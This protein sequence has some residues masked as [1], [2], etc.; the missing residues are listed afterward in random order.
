MDTEIREWFDEIWAYC[1][2]NWVAVLAFAGVALVLLLSV[3]LISAAKREDRKALQEQDV[4]ETGAEEILPDVEPEPET[5]DEAE[6]ETETKPEMQAQEPAE[7]GE[8]Q[9]AAMGMVDSLVKSMERA[10]GASGQ[11]VES[12]ELKIEKAQLTIRYAGDAEKNVTEDLLAEKTSKEETAAADAEVEAAAEPETEKT[13]FAENSGR[14]KRFGFDNMNT[15]RSGR[16][17]TEEELLDQ[18]KD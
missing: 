5:E 6:S 3:V 18:I 10:A 13:D 1:E 9:E 8:L 11:K 2:E 17:Y 12:I 16:V 14:P 4:Q 15:A 7:T